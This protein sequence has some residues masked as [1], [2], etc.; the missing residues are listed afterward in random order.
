MQ[1]QTTESP[2]NGAARR[3]RAHGKKAPRLYEA[4]SELDAD[5]G[6]WSDGFIFDEV[7]G[8]PGLSHDDRMLVAIVALAAN[9][10]FEQL[11]YYIRGALEAGV[12]PSRIHESLLML[13][14]YCGFPRALSALAVLK[15]VLASANA[16]AEN[17][18]N[19]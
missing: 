6:R 5:L 15:Q 16:T 3:E 4:I 8:R 12:P 18:G 14:V 7:W 9:G 17:D 19:A 10:Q 11:R 13:V 1:E 2:T